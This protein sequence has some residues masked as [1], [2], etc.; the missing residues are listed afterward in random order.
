M[1]DCRTVEL[2]IFVTAATFEDARDKARLIGR[3]AE[4][5]DETFWITASS[6]PEAVDR[7]GCLV[8][9]CARAKR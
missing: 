4:R 1:C 3:D 2:R 9:F 8:G 7:T 6:Y 5:S